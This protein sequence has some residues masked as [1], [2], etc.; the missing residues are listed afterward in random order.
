M[1][2]SLTSA[3]PGMSVPD[4][5][6]CLSE[7]RLLLSEQN[8]GNP[9][10]MKKKLSNGMEIYNFVHLVALGLHQKR[11]KNR[12]KGRVDADDDLSSD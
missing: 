1:S 6:R 3:I 4:M 10:D 12:R 2:R 11:M 9:F 7:V 8:A 5:R